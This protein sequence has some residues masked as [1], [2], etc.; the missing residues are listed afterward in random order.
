[1]RAVTEAPHPLR[2]RRGRVRE[3][4]RERRRGVLD[5]RRRRDADRDRRRRSDRGRR[6][7]RHRDE[8]RRHR[9]RGVDGHRAGAGTGAR[10][11]PA[12][13]D[14]AGQGGLRERDRGS[15]CDRGGAGAGAGDAA[16]ARGD[17]AAASDRDGQREARRGA[18]AT[19]TAPM[20]QWEPCGRATPRWSSAGQAP[21]RPASSAG[22]AA[23]GR[24][25]SVCPPLFA[26]AP[27][28]GSTPC[29]SR[30]AARPQLASDARFDPWSRAPRCSRR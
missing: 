24:Y 2:G 20:S 29:W 21:S 9:G 30:A 13:E 8:R 3:R 15:A 27:S 22:L 25:V 14:V 11:G 5:R 26:S 1:M 7:R 6:R 28:C 18:T 12:G 4:R 19:S 17:R 10:A 23:P 16:G